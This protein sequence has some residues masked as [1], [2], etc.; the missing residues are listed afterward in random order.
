MFELDSEVRKWKAH[1]ASTGSLSYSDLEELESHLCDSVD[2]LVAKGLSQEEAFL[3]A[4][5]R[6]GDATLINEEYAKVSTEDMWRQLLVPA[7][8]ALS[9]R[10]N[11]TEMALVLLLALCAGLSSRGPALFGYGDIDAN[12]LLYLRL[13]PVIVCFPLAIYFLWKR[14]LP[15]LRSLVVLGIFP[16]YLVISTLYPSWEPNHTAML[17]AMHA[18]IVMVFLLLYFYGG[19][20]LGSSAIDGVH[21]HG[22]WRNANTR[23]NFIRFI[24]EFFIFSVLIGLGGIVLILLTMGTF[25]LIGI[26]LSSFVSSWMAPLGFF[27][28]FPVAAYLVGQKKNLIE[29]IAPVLA[30]IFT[31]L[32]LVVLISLI[33]AFLS[34]VHDAYGNR[35]M[36]IWFDII[37]AMV[38][39]LTLYS[40]SA[41]DYPGRTTDSARRSVWDVLTLSLIVVAVAVD[42]IALSGI[43]VRLNAYGFTANKTAALGE[44][45]MLLV[46]LLLLM[47]G[48]L[49]YCRGRRRFQEIVVMQMRF[50]DAYVLW[51]VFVIVIFP[52]LFGFR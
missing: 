4:V 3:L 22:G 45:L 18:P 9:N 32:F 35:M 51:A 36:L 26:D 25:E 17:G 24:G 30:K 33:V 5:R 10:R 29:S 27:G 43:I 13:F 31:P 20:D 38:L 11:K 34:T 19:P 2:S 50:L 23:L 12:E 14:S 37:L 42:L 48:Y 39:A 49:R 47:V 21:V 44:N 1:I 52:L 16:L 8:N 6:L 46:N 15:L 41:K 40:M 7:E 28:I